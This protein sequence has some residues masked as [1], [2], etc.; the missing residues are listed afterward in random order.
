MVNKNIS[1]C[2]YFLLCFADYSRWKRRL[3]L[4][5]LFKRSLHCKMLHLIP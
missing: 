4:H 1:N 2:I 5:S 3:L